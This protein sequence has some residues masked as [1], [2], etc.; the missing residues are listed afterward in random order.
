MST[1]P[2]PARHTA[3]TPGQAYQE[4]GECGTEDRLSSPQRGVAT[5]QTQELTFLAT[6]E[7]QECDW[8]VWQQIGQ[9]CQQKEGPELRVSIPYP[10]PSPW[11]TRRLLGLNSFLTLLLLRKTEAEMRFN[12]SSPDA[13][14]EVFIEKS[15]AEPA[16]M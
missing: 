11:S 16:S 3:P 1:D 9:T 5:S 14:P 7:A 12:Q 13:Q 15:S 2:V 4:W 6:A 10:T 8:S